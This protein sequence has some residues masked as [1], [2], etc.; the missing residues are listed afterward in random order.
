MRNQ[1]G[2]SERQNGRNFRSPL[3]GT[4]SCVSSELLSRPDGH[5]SS[6]RSFLDSGCVPG[7]GLG[8]GN[9]DAKTLEKGGGPASTPAAFCVGTRC[10][11]GALARLSAFRFNSHPIPASG[12]L[13]VLSSVPRMLFPWIFSRLAPPQH[14]GLSSKLLLQRGLSCLV[15]LTLSPVFIYSVLFSSQLPPL[16]NSHFVVYC[17]CPTNRN[18][19]SMRTGILFV[20]FSTRS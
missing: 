10:T 20:L 19:R 2:E 13:D 14:I 5:C 17:L 1:E 12:P 11:Q 3:Q 8:S 6:T 9:P 16:W 4:G 15:L 7:T 18:G